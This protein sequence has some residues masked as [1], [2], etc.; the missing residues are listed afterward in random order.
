MNRSS[1]SLFISP[2]DHMQPVEDHLESNNRMNINI[3]ETLLSP[4]VMIIYRVLALKSQNLGP[5]V[6]KQ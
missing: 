1:V 4:N 2:V 5:D 6:T 3:P